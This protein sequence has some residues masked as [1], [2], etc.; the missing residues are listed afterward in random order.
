MTD[1]RGTEHPD[2]SEDGEE[3]TPRRRRKREAARLFGA[4]LK[5]LG[6]AG[7]QEAVAAALDRSRATIRKWLLDDVPPEYGDP[8]LIPT[9]TFEA[10]VALDPPGMG[11]FARELCE[12]MG[13]IAGVREN[14]AP[15]AEQGVIATVRELEREGSESI[16]ALLA[17]IEAHGDGGARMTEPELQRIV[18]QLHEDI[19]VRH[20]ALAAVRKAISR[21]S[22]FATRRSLQCGRRSRS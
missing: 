2:L 17:A 3:E 15:L 9:V 18:C 20:Q 10:I 11:V 21:T 16:D 6:S 7:K 19:G 13:W 22:A 8:E 14:I 12:R 4:A 1:R 5:A